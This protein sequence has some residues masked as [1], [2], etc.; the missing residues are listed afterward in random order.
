MSRFTVDVYERE[1]ER[2][3]GAAAMA[4]A[5]SLYTADSRAVLELLRLDQ[6]GLTRYDRTELAVASIDD[7]LA[8]LSLDEADRLRCYRRQTPQRRS[9]APS[10]GPAK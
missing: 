5:E 1:I 4:L 7:L 3:G 6:L 8:G 9:P 10:T 2:Y